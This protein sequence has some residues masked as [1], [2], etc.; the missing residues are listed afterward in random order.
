M[1]SMPPTGSEWERP[2]QPL[3]LD[4]GFQGLLTFN[5]IPDIPPRGFHTITII[6]HLESTTY[7]THCRKPSQSPATMEPKESAMAE[8]FSTPRPSNPGSS[9]LRPWPSGAGYG[10][11]RRPKKARKGAPGSGQ[12]EYR[13]K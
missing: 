5:G 6:I 8:G 10:S 4:N 2:P 12:S 11:S 3:R 9:K 13:E 1:R 7:R